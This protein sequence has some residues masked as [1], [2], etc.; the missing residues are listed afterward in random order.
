MIERGDACDR[1]EDRGQLP[2]RVPAREQ[3]IGGRTVTEGQR[4]AVHSTSGRGILLAMKTLS[5]AVLLFV[6]VSAFSGTRV[7]AAPK[8]E[9][10]KGPSVDTSFLKQYAETRGF[11]LGRPQK[12]K[13]TLDGKAI[14]F[15]RSDAKTPRQ[16]LFEFDVATGK[17]RELLAPDTLVKNAEENLT[18]E[19]KAR[20]ERQRVS[21]GGFT[22]FHLDAN[23][24]FVL[25]KLL[26]RL[27][28]FDRSNA[29]VVELKV[30]EGGAVVDPKWSPDGKHVA[31]VRGFDVYVYDIAAGAERPLTTGGTANKTHGLAEFV[32]QEEMHRHTG[33]WWSPDSKHIAYE[34]ADHTGIETWY[35]ADP[36]KP[37]VKPAEQFYPRPGK[38]NV[39]VRLGV[40][41]TTGG[42][43]VWVEWDRAAYEYMAAVKWDDYAPLTVQVQDRKQQ[44]LALLSV[45]ITTGKTKKLVEEKDAAWV[46]IVP[47]GP[48][49]NG[50]LG[51]FVWLGADK[52][53]ETE[54][55]LRDWNGGRL[56]DALVPAS[57]K[58]SEIISVHNSR[59]DTYIV[60]HGGT[61]PTQRHVYRH[62]MRNLNVNPGGPDEP[63]SRDVG[64]H[65]RVVRQIRRAVCHHL[66][67]AQGDAAEH[68]LFP[69]GCKALRTGIGRGR[70]AVHAERA[71][72]EGR[73]RG[74]L[75]RRHRA[76]AG[77]RREEEIPCARVRLRRA[78]VEVCHT[79][80]AAVARAAVARRPGLYCRGHRQPW[81][82]RP[83]P[84]VGEGRVSEVRHGAAR[85]SSRGAEGAVQEVPGDGRGSR[86]H[87]RLVLRR[88]YGREC[89]AARA[90]RL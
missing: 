13:I 46:N 80:G 49:F 21:V 47:E 40:I 65:Q 19:E 27:Y 81:H 90:G 78:D 54:I 17:S 42:Q 15:L 82:L 1:D 29:N 16:G 20:R 67:H 5:V 12:P 10:A 83:R 50:A 66:D 14:L 51:G 76:A 30:G 4:H 2:A 34:E 77:L 55:Q 88:V 56:M 24:R 39:A 64:M 84:G 53:G 74:G 25:L 23:G 44:T 22:D 70:A 8:A 18:P 31:Y 52:D 35:V 63:L 87:R 26:N 85:G 7:P 57:Q 86:R 60:Y 36:F 28:I 69:R 79:G 48:R 9:D 43:T 32:A 11:M 61:D 33:F 89:G 37:D 41:P 58:P 6:V 73:R 38:K 68:G 3:R 59:F 62:R 75:L 71:D 45:D 72:P